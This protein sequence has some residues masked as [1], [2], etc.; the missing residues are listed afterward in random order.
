MAYRKAAARAMTNK[1]CKQMTDLIFK[2]VND[3]L[4]AALQ[5]DFQR[6]LAICPDCVAFLNTYRKTI[7][8]TGSVRAEDIPAKVRD[9]LLKF[10]RQRA[11]EHKRNP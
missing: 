6:H 5:K 2:Y 3:N 9:N 11:D 7:A 4:G 8:V 10:L 1:T